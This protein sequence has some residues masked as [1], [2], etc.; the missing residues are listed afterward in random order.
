MDERQATVVRAAVLSATADE[1]AV[2]EGMF[3]AWR[4]L[5][6]GGSLGMACRAARVAAERHARAELAR[7]IREVPVGLVGV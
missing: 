2:Q 7:R 3:C 5:A 4:V 6:S 1:D